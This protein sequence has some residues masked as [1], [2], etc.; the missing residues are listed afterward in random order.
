MFASWIV[1][2]RKIIPLEPHM[3]LER[4]VDK[5]FFFYN[6]YFVHAKIIRHRCHRRRRKIARKTANFFKLNIWYLY[7]KNK[8]KNFADF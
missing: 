5:V 1:N 8:N 7:Y 3:K 2:L 4:L 6:M